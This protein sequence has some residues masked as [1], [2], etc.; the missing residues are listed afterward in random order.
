MIL[1]LECFQRI[2]K[3]LCKLTTIQLFNDMVCSLQRF[4]SSKKGITKQSSD[5]LNNTMVFSEKGDAYTDSQHINEGLMTIE[6]RDLAKSPYNFDK[7]K[8]T[9]PQKEGSVYMFQ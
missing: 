9:G 8:V 5:K 6:S 1:K 3:D 4:D 7:I 2:S